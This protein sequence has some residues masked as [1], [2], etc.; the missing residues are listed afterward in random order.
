MQFEP[1]SFRFSADIVRKLQHIHHARNP[2]CELD[3]YVCKSNTCCV[4]LL[5]VQHVSNLD[6]VIRFG[7]ACLSKPKIADTHTLFAHGFSTIDNRSELIEE[8]SQKLLAKIRQKA[9]DE[10]N[11]NICILYDTN[12]I[13][14]ATKLHKSIQD[15]DLSNQIEVARLHMTWP[16]WDSTA[17]SHLL[18]RDIPSNKFGNFSLFRPITEYNLVIYIGSRLSIQQTLDCPSNLYKVNYDESMDMERVNVSKLLNRRIALIGRLKDEVELNFG[19]IITNPLPDVGQLM[20]R[21]QSYADARKH[22][23]Y[24]ITM[25]QT[26]D[27]CKIGNFDLCDAFLVVNSCTCSTILESLVFN[28]PIITELEFKLA[29]GFEAEYG[30][31]LWPPSSSHLSADDIINRRKVSDVSQ[32]LIH[33]RNELLERC[34]LSRANKWSGMDYGPSQT[35]AMNEDKTIGGE[36]LKIEEGLH[37]IASMYISEPLKKNSSGTSDIK[38]TEESSK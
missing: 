35:S 17:P 2:S 30:R 25:V 5:I 15:L 13:G 23:L 19:V 33:M 4:D 28:R 11:S 12:I 37:G 21:L 14:L 22:T 32:S 36:S 26:I 9:L 27:E 1:D 10:N 20:S 18:D 38:P 24:Y 3:L 31:V 34:S 8:R 29:C 16:E 7:N 6:G